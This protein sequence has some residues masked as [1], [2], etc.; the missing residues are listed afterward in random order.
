M[1]KKKIHIE[2]YIVDIT[3]PPIFPPGRMIKEHSGETK[4]SKLLGV[5]WQLY[6]KEYN[7]QRMESK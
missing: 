5:A 3:N 2:P 7:K 4:H 1:F 6:I